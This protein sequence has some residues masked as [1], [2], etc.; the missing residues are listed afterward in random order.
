MELPNHCVLYEWKKYTKTTNYRNSKNN[1][2]HFFRL[3]RNRLICM[4]NSVT[5]NASRQDRGQENNIYRHSKIDWGKFSSLQNDDTHL[6]GITS[7][8]TMC[9]DIMQL[10][11]LLYIIIELIILEVVLR[12]CH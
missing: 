8:C 4:F 9:I 2:S 10:S 3:I 12:N 7:V 5:A 1:T 6:Y 11:L